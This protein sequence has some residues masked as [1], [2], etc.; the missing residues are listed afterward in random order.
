MNSN[1]E[2]AARW[3]QGRRAAADGHLSGYGSSKNSAK[4]AQAFIGDIIKRYNPKK[5]L[6]LGCGDWTWFSS[7]GDML[8][9]SGVEYEG[10]DACARMIRDNNEKYGNDS[11][12]FMLKDIVTEEYPKVDL[13]IC[14]DVLFHLQQSMALEVIEKVHK[15][16]SLFISTTFPYTTTNKKLTGGWGFYTINLAIDPFSL[17]RYEVEKRHEVKCG[18]KNN[19]RF[20]CMYELN[21]Y[22]Q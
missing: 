11:V 15:S 2:T 19:M 8:D 17:S 3:V 20:V 9:S 7:L 10:W 12:R 5:I 4:D 6:D 14:R 18:Q 21:K 1:F 13:I 16:C 22:N